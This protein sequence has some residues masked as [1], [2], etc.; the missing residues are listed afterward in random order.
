MRLLPPARRLGQGLTGAQPGRSQRAPTRVRTREA[1]PTL[2]RRILPPTSTTMA[3]ARP[4]DLGPLAW[5]AAVHRR[6]FRSWHAPSGKAR[7]RV[8]GVWSNGFVGRPDWARPYFISYHD[9]SRRRRA[10]R[11]PR[12]CRRRTE[13]TGRPRPARGAGLTSGAGRAGQAGRL[14][15]SGPAGGT[16][17]GSGVHRR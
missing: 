13:R 11:Q 12:R 14:R 10:V 4:G 9:L 8:A 6:S 1:A 16:G 5:R 7:R 2:Y 3:L 15:N 17:T